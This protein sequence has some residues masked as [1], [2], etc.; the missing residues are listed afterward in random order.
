MKKIKPVIQEDRTGCGLACVAAVAGV[1]Y[2]QSKEVAGRL[3]ISVANDALWS[4]ATYLR[5]LLKHFD[6]IAAARSQ[7]FRSWDS[8]SDLALLATKWHLE[9]GWPYWHWT[10][11]LREDGAARVLDSKKSLR[12]HSRTD[13][14][15]IKPK[16][17][18]PLRRKR[19]S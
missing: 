7:P 17:W 15:R 8:V 9:R 18:I 19:A 13:L 16:W 12:N 11:F 3:G 5:R 4:Q 6:V 1:T 2:Q 10:L 14:G